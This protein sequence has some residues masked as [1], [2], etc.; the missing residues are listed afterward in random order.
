MPEP[1]TGYIDAWRANISY[2]SSQCWQLGNALGGA[3]EWIG[4][5]NWGYAEM[6]LDAAADYAHNMAHEFKFES[7]GVWTNMYNAMHWVDENIG[8]D[9]ELTMQMILDAIWQSD[10]T[11]SF[12]FINDIDAMRA[13]IWNMEIYEGSLENWYR[14]FMYPK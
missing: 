8:G 11:Q 6:Y 14:H 2:I 9:G 1:L 3:A 13:S 5:Q 12:E 4:K 7:A 10:K